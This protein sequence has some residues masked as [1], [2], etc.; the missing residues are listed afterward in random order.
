MSLKGSPCLGKAGLSLRWPS[1]SW[2]SWAT[3]RQLRALTPKA[4]SFFLPP[5]PP[6]VATSSISLSVSPLP[7]SL[8]LPLDW[9]A[10]PT[11]PQITLSKHTSD[12]IC[13]ACCSHTPGPPPPPGLSPF[14]CKAWFLLQDHLCPGWRLPPGTA[15]EGLVG[16]GP[17]GLAPWSPPPLPCLPFLL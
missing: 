9:L 4:G 3:L 5:G 6:T 15:G 8:L 11:S 17:R 1:Y 14:A 2:D 10:I 13:P 12:H 7:A 16:E